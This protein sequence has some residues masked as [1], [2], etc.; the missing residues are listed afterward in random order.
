LAPFPSTSS[1]AIGGNQREER[2][3]KEKGI[4]KQNIRIF[5]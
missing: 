2:D 1:R 5:V 4:E 3:E